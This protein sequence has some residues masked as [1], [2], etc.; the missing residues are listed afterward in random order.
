MARKRRILE[1]IGIAEISAVDHPCQEHA[2]VAIMKRAPNPC[3][4]EPERR[5]R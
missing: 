3:I 5:P 1:K 4:P 2:R